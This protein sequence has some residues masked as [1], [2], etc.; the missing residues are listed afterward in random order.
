M[1]AS[2]FAV[3]AHGP[4]LGPSYLSQKISNEVQVLARTRMA[5]I[6]AKSFRREGHEKEGYSRAARQFAVRPW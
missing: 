2:G 5:P 1:A 3:C 4:S 6:P